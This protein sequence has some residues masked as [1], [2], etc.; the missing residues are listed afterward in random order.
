MNFHSVFFLDQ[1]M[2]WIIEIISFK[3]NLRP[4]SY[5]YVCEGNGGEHTRLRNKIFDLTARAQDHRTWVF[6]PTELRVQ[7][8]EGRG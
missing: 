7:V 1:L 4:F 5:V 2:A 3:K 8:G 6:L